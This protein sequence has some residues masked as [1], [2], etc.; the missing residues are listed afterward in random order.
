MNLFSKYFTRSIA[1]LFFAGVAFIPVNAKA[2]KGP[3]LTQSF[4]SVSDFHFNPYY[5]PSLVDTLIKTSYTGWRGIFESSAVQQPNG[6]GSDANYPLFKSA[7]AAMQLQNT[8]PAFIVISGDFLCHDFQANFSQYAPGSSD[9]LQSF[10]SKTIWFMADMLNKYFP[11]TVVLPVLGNNDSYCGD[12]MLEPNGPFLSMFA[13]AWVRLLRNN[14]PVAD[15]AFIKQFSKGGYY[16]YSTKNSAV[17][18]VMMNSV[19]F[20]AK[21]SN[22]C[23]VPGEDPARDEFT[24][25]EQELAICR[26]K[27]QGAWMVYHIPPGI[28]VHSTLNG[29]ASS[30]QENIKTMWQD[31]LNSKFL[32]LVIKYASTIRGSLAG[33]THMDDFRV[34]YN[35]RSTPI[36]FIHITPAVSP[37]FGNNPGFQRITFIY[38]T[39]QLINNETFYLAINK[40]ATNWT[41]EYNFQLTYGVTGINTATMNTVRRKIATDSVIRSRYINLYK[42]S[43]PGSNEINLKNWKAF[44]CGT[45]AITRQAF[46][47]CYC[48]VPP[49][50]KQ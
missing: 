27:E 46:S 28:D 19:F 17:K 49:G 25:L 36:S 12:Y 9:S 11:S 15:T 34:V 30:C 2:Q 24:W 39:M 1:I 21:Y 8:H 38:K 10:T 18:F 5:D 31:S 29:W 33:H 35:Q 47:A 26:A 50:N 43:N 45:G 48:T 14:N 23:G 3:I 44:W 4:L 16:T 37:L 40:H 32:N 42:V 6:Y 20:S 41:P 13:R 22:A 7:L